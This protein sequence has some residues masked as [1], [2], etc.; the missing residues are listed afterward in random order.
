MTEVFPDKNQNDRMFS[1]ASLALTSEIDFTEIYSL[2]Q[3]M[4][5]P[6]NKISSGSL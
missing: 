6:N 3:I 5:W 4:T 1:K 2:G